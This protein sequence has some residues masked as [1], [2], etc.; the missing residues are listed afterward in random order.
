M[1]VVQDGV[2]RFFVVL[3]SRTTRTRVHDMESLIL[4]KN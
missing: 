2:K 3:N 1:S 4:D